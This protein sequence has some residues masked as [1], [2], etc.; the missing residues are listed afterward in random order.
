VLPAQLVRHWLA[1]TFLLAVFL[2]F[3]IGVRIGSAGFYNGSSGSDVFVYLPAVFKPIPPPPWQEVGIGSSAN[4]GISMDDTNS[5]LPSVA[6]GANGTIYITWAS[7]YGTG[8]EIYV[9]RWNGVSWEEAGAGSASGGGISNNSSVSYRPSITITPAG[10]PYVAWDDEINES[11]E[12]YVRRWNGSSWEEV[13][14][15]SASD[16][17]VSNTAGESKR[18]SLSAA[19]DGTVYLAWDETVDNNREIYVRRWDGT[20]WQEVGSGSA[21]GGGVSNTPTHSSDPSLVVA[22][23]GTPYVAWHEDPGF[24][25]GDIY[26]RRWNGSS[27]EEVG[28]GSASSGGINQNDSRA[29]RPSLAIG[30]DGIPYVAWDDTGGGGTSIYI[31]RWDG[32][33]WVEVGAGSATGSGISGNGQWSVAPSVAVAPDNTVYVAWNYDMASEEIYV[34]QWN[35]SNWLEAGSGA[36]T[37]GGISNNDSESDS[38]SLTI[39]PE[40]TIYVAWENW[41]MGDDEIYIRRRLP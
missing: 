34:K 8:L 26:V 31:R 40:G 19:P 27:W 32:N 2:V 7:Y 22:P 6:S 1:A 39:A 30:P 25:G 36:A 24:S 37:G 38:P 15:G 13:G 3:L 33:N 17:G 5:W 35:G 41:W 4:G 29:L 10:T 21:S 28:L 12:I 11:E 18:P 14:S 16:G 9:R 23:N 20:S